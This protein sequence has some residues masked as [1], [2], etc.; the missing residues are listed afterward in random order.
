[1]ADKALLTGI[2]NY[3]SISDLR[4]CLNDVNDI[5]QLLLEVFGFS[6]QNIRTLTDDKVTKDQI[7]K[8]WR[9][10][11]DGAAPG[12]RLVFQ[13][14]GHGSQIADLDDDEPDDVDEILCLYD[15]DWDSKDTYLVDDDLRKLINRVPKGVLLTVILDSCHSGTAT[16]LLMAPDDARTVVAPAKAPL[17]DLQTT[18]ARLD[19][20]EERGT[21]LSVREAG[22]AI[23]RILRPVEPDETRDTVLVRYVEPPRKVLETLS[24]PEVRRSHLLRQGAHDV[25]K[26][27][28]VLL[29]GSKSL[30][31]CADAYIGQ[32][33]HGAFSY[34]LCQTVRKSGADLE[35]QDF[36]RQVR[37][38][39]ASGRFSQVPQLEPADTRGPLLR[40][41][42]KVPKPKPKP[43]VTSTSA[44]SEE[45]LDL[46][47]E[48]KEM[49]Q[50]GRAP[51][52]Q[53]GRV[54]GE[55]AL[56]YV[57][58]I[59]RHPAGYSAPWWRSLRPHLSAELRQAL[60]VHRREV[61][62]SDL[63]TA[64]R[65]SRF[66]PEPRQAER[67]RELADLLREVLEDRAERE[68]LHAIPAPRGD[69]VPAEA[70]HFAERQERG[71]PD[72]SGIDDFVK[73]LV[74]D[75]VRQAVQ[76][77]F[78]DETVPL[79]KSG[80]AVEVVSHSWGTVVAYEAL[81]SLD[82]E[83]FAGQVH[84]L[85]TV[86][87]AL[88]IG[89]VRNRVRPRDGRRPRCVQ[90]WVNLDAGGD[91][92][93]GPL[94]G[95][96]EVDREY[97]NLHPSGCQAVIGLVTPTCAHGSYFH[98]SNTAVNRHIFAQQMET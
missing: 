5:K 74:N 88:S 50:E 23:E 78:L 56:V 57:H 95:R 54:A 48:I 90:R 14:S 7:Y 16:R 41:G 87:S 44:F 21:S 93:G 66:E 4:G 89:L 28:H 68:S 69:E 60:E 8:Q 15:M 92:V 33:F 63:V 1:M 12:D 17:V 26:M 71:L 25:D 43:A 86:G 10:L 65:A 20:T 62:W 27:N 70:P 24:R 55:P 46:V 35:H 45:L 19:G 3:Q 97:L 11:C 13:F 2:N 18:M 51:L 58:G 64:D 59:G 94:R 98:E 73:Y 22:Q 31:T 37:K 36:I 47:R 79:L 84:N 76:Q 49:L 6:R 82:G 61:L 39:V 9:W 72:M 38:A 81:R 52:P 77:R 42:G 29:A 67:E 85:F 80:A 91:I 53:A 83:S 32:D 75:S 30:Q 96:F 40:W 34:Y